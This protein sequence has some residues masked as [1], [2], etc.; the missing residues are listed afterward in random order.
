MRID[1]IDAPYNEPRE[2]WPDCTK[3][4]V[5]EITPVYIDDEIIIIEPE[6]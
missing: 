6:V 2:E 1:E 4:I 3:E 5:V